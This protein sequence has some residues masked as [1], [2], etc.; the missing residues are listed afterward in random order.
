MSL[1]IG[2]S[3]GTYIGLKAASKNPEK[4]AAYIGIGQVSNH[5]ISE[6]DSLEYTIRQ[7]QQAG[8]LKDVDQ[9]EFLR[10]SIKKGEAHTPRNMVRKY[11]GTARLI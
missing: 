8:N 9:L 5:I 6:M 11:G 1:L 10:D 7:A 4:Y 2:H 3:F